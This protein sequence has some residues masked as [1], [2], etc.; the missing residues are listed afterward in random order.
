VK[1][2]RLLANAKSIAVA[3]SVR[4]PFIIC[5]EHQDSSEAQH[6]IILAVHHAGSFIRIFADPMQAIY[7]KNRDHEA[8]VRRWD[9][10]QAAADEYAE[11]D[12]PHRWK[13][14][15]P[16]LG[17]WIKEVREN[18]KAGQTV[19]L[20]GDLPRELTLIR[21][22][23]VAQRHG[24]YILSPDH[25]SPIDNFVSASSELLILSSTK[26]TVNGLRAFFNRGL[27]IWEGHTRDALSKLALSCHECSGTPASVADVFIEFVQNVAC[28]F[29]NSAYGE[30]FRQE[31]V[32]RCSAPRRQKRS[33]IQ[34]IAK[35]IIE[36]PDHRGIALA[37]AKLGELMRNDDSFSDIK[38]DL[39]REFKEAIRLGRYDDINEGLT[40]LHMHRTVFR[41]SLPPK[42]ISTVHKA[43]GLEKETVLVVP[44]DR[45]HFG[46]S[47]AKRR[48]LYVALSR[49]TKSLALV[50]PYS[51]PSPLFR[52]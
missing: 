35:H 48:L 52:A 15:A 14:S 39:W 46:D 23:N 11:L 20:R 49:A 42:T 22:D 30:A 24:L 6:Q 12:T 47:D 44:C 18:L 7:K 5:D 34:D 10:L 43:K 32:E 33:K 4:Y 28:G 3:L 8:W 40:H 1:V 50:V 16:E 21:A 19:D 13:N 41:A 51:S 17:E 38:L 25:R 26:D 37:L 27:P 45:E 36:C 2:A 31:I 29:S 9:A